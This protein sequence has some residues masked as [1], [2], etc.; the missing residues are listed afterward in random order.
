[1]MELVKKKTTI[2][3]G[4]DL[5]D[6]SCPLVMGILNLTPDSFFD[7]GRYFNQDDVKKRID[8]IV[9]QGAQIIDVG[10][11][12]SRPG[13]DDVPVEEEKRRLKMFFDVFHRYQYDILVSIDT[14]RSEVV[15]YCYD[16][17][18]AFIVNDISAGEI[19][20]NMYK[21]VGELKLPYIAMHMQG[22]PET[23]QQNPQ[24]S[25]V[26]SDIIKYFSNKIAQLKSY[27]IVDIIIDP[28]FGFGK[29]LDHNYHLLKNLK[30]LNMLAC[31]V[32]VGVSRKSMI[33]KFLNSSPD[34]TLAGTVALN[35][36]SLQNGAN[37]IRVHDVKE[38][39]DTVKI[40]EKL[41]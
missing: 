39:V 26:T 17:F 14:F 35:L 10:A 9:D 36:F 29:T 3:Y 12:S 16:I 25:N 2:N 22:T 20:N 7:G 11:Y 41:L 13:A 37:I 1:M 32:L 6:L 15:E 28:G 23:M 8:T 19:D 34:E 31:P 33:Y 21:V 5:I 30:A 4:G 38:A 27:G 18:G 24:Y 40:Y